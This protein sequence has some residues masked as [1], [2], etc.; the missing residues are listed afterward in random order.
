MLQ[1]HS[2]TLATQ[3]GKPSYWLHC[4][5]RDSLPPLLLLP[6]TQ[7][8]VSSLKRSDLVVR[9]VKDPVTVLKLKLSWSLCSPK[10]HF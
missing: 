1:R 4:L 5:H 9:D 8:Q 2:E 3:S 6:Y 10:A 7:L